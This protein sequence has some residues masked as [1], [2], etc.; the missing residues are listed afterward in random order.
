MDTVESPNK[1]QAILERSFGSSALEGGGGGRRQMILDLEDVKT[2]K[3]MDHATM[4][5]T[6]EP[7]NKEHFRTSHFRGHSEVKG[8]LAIRTVSIWDPRK[9]SCVGMCSLF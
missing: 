2:S 8:V 7:P 5:V 1:G 4:R 3:L 6:V 9:E